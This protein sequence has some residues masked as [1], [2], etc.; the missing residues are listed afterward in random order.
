MSLRRPAN[1]YRS[2]LAAK[3][4]GVIIVVLTGV[5]IDP[6]ATELA[7]LLVI[8]NLASLVAFL[9]WIYRIFR[10]AETRDFHQVAPSSA[11]IDYFIPVVGLYKPR[12]DLL[13]FNGRFGG[14]LSKDIRGWW[15][16]AIVTSIVSVIA[17][18]IPTVHLLNAFLI[19]PLYAVITWRFVGR[20]TDFVEKLERNEFVPSPE[21]Q[22]AV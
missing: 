11:V 8:A 16:A 21:F 2:L 6:R 4:F 13:D 10:I 19:A 17:T 1:V 7:S 18:L 12:N 14:G 22:L 5:L 9:V 3:T 15:A 20:M